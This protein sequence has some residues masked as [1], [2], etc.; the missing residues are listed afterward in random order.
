M[1]MVDATATLPQHALVILRRLRG[2][3][4]T[5]FELASHIADASGYTTEQAAEKIA[6]WLDELRRDGL[7]WAGPLSNASGQQ[8]VAAALTNRG[9]ELLG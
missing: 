9:R 6:S 7:V 8:I 4:L 1:V 2:G 3:P 5:E